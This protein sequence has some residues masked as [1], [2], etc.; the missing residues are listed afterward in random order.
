[1]IEFS[2]SLVH[3]IVDKGEPNANRPNSRP[4]K[5]HPDCQAVQ[6]CWQGYPASY[7]LGS[8]DLQFTAIGHTMTA[9]GESD[10]IGR[11][12]VYFKGRVVWGMNYFGASCSMIRSHPPR[13]G[14]HP[15]EPVQDVPGGR[16]WVD[17]STR[18]GV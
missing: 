15:A 13:Q 6:L 16:F 2:R 10:F 3:Q 11:E 4:G 14:G 18:R 17:F 7:R 12:I 8:H 9:T 5:F 1:M